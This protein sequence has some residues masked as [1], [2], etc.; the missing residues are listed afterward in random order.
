[1]ASRK[2]IKVTTKW[3]IYVEVETNK[4]KVVKSGWN[5][6]FN[7][8]PIIFDTSRVMRTYFS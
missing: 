4:M 5:Y 3:Y 1:M 7:A 8:N 2:N 6:Y